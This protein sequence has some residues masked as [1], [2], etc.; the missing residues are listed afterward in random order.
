MD[1]VNFPRAYFADS[2]HQ[3][4]RIYVAGGVYLIKWQT[5]VICWPPLSQIKPMVEACLEA[6]SMIMIQFYSGQL[7]AEPVVICRDMP[8]LG[9][10]PFIPQGKPLV[11]NLPLS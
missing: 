9:F 7:K 10:A 4:Y 6:T 5:A 11:G 3:L 1:N 8:V 2:P